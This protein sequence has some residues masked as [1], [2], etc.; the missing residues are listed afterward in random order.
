MPRHQ[1]RPFVRRSR[2]IFGSQMV[3]LPVAQS[4][5]SGYKQACPVKPV[6]ENYCTR[7]VWE[8]G[9]VSG[10]FNCSAQEAEAGRS[11]ESL[12]PA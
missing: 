8:L 10:V 6:V 11:F 9:I 12:K 1:A 3:P 5:P 2:Q 7:K 4:L